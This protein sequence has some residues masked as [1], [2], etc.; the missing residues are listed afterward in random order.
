MPA[1]KES[2]STEAKKKTLTIHISTDHVGPHGM[3]L[4]YGSTPDKIGTIK[5]TVRFETNYDC[6][7][8]DIVILYE[9]KAEAQWTALENK[10]VVNHHTEEIFGHQTWQF[11]LKHTRPNGLTVVAGKYEKEFEV[12]LIHPSVLNRTSTPPLSAQ[13]TSATV[14]A[15]TTTSSGPNPLLPSS[16][17]SPNAKMKYIIRAILLR[18][19]PCITDIEAS[20]E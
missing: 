20:Q 14:N 16:S 2:S 13:S 10:K 12:P 8:R 6:R 15:S 7:G 5:G 18:P 9:A 17:Y 19:F 1:S 11:P 4:V 3:P